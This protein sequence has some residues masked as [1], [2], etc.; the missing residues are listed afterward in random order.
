MTINLNKLVTIGLITASSV[1]LGTI[2]PIHLSKMPVKAL[3]TSSMYT[4][5]RKSPHL[6]RSAATHTTPGASSNY[7][8]TIEVPEDAGQSLKAVAIR[9]QPNLETI[10]FDLNQSEAFLGDSFA[11]G[12]MVP[13]SSIGGEESDQVTIVFDEPVEPGNTVTISL[14][15]NSNPQFGGIYQFDVIAFSSGDDLNGLN[16]GSARLSFENYN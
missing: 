1:V 14:K 12:P 4:G 9:Q 15:A 5:F 10:S 16:L 8:I 7:Q 11:G 13:I 3:E 2:A 6:V